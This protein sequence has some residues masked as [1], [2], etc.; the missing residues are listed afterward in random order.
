MIRGLFEFCSTTRASQFIRIDFPKHVSA[1]VKT[2]TCS[3]FLTVVVCALNNCITNHTRL[4]DAFL[5]QLSF[6]F[7]FPFQILAGNDSCNI[8][9]CVL[10]SSLFCSAQPLI[11]PIVSSTSF[12]ITGVFTLQILCN[13]FGIF[14]RQPR[15]LKQ[16]LNCL[17]R[18]GIPALSNRLSIA[19]KENKKKLPKHR[20]RHH[21]KPP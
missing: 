1:T 18:I 20:E 10:L 17:I 19:L 9:Q 2:D 6:L 11:L 3:T 16:D 4:A 7:T 13:S 15:M 8:R 21:E 14:I 12:R 5:R